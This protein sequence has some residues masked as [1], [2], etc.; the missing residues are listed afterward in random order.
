M[1]RKFVAIEKHTIVHTDSTAYRVKPNP[2]AEGGY[3][4]G[5]VLEWS[6]DGKEWQ[7]HF[8]IAPEAL[9][10]LAT[11]LEEAAEATGLDV[12]RSDML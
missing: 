2:D 5:A 10:A 7:G 12:R 3:R 11:A 8:Y 6:D 4:D 9:G 1:A